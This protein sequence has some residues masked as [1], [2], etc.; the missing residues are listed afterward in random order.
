MESK[1][2]TWLYA[3]TYNFCINY[4]QRVKGKKEATFKSIE[5]I[6]YK[7][8]VEVPEEQLLSLKTEKL[9]QCLN[10][11][12]HLDRTILLMKYQD[13]FSIKDIMDAYQIQESAVKMRLA[14]AKSKL[15]KLYNR[16]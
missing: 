7:T 2:S 13:D 1:F 15:L 12:N 8:P 11:L 9:A 3:F 6:E 10:R 16:L 4:V 5:E 14:R